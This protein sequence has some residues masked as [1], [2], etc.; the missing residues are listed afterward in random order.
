[1]IFHETDTNWNFF[2]ISLIHRGF[3]TIIISSDLNKFSFL[4]RHSFLIFLVLF[5]LRY[6][7]SFKIWTEALLVTNCFKRIFMVTPSQCTF[8]IYCFLYI[9]IVFI[10]EW[11]YT[12]CILNSILC[13]SSLSIFDMYL[14]VVGKM[15]RY[16]KHMLKKNQIKWTKLFDCDCF[17]AWTAMSFDQIIF[18]FGCIDHLSY[19][20]YQT[21]IW[22]LYSFILIRFRYRGGEQI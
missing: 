14:K 5:S 11:T 21:T 16:L 15:F 8:H 7:L 9:L 19:V 1:M 4:F 13:V 2:W 17:W 22:F 20:H 18:E 6:F 10:G 3:F 12:N